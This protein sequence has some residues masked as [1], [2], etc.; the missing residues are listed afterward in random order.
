M[1]RVPRQRRLP[2]VCYFFENPGDQSL[3]NNLPFP[4]RSQRWVTP[5]AGW[6]I[7]TFFLRIS[8]Q[9]ASRTV[10]VVVFYRFLH[11]YAC[12]ID[13]QHY[14]GLDLVRVSAALLF[15]NTEEKWNPDTPRRPDRNDS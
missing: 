14:R 6:R 12:R 1:P 10:A 3:C 5:D 13:V 11:V 15:P 8:R 9:S 2:Q 7:D 4:S